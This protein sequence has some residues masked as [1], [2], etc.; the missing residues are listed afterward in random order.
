MN[1]PLLWIA[2]PASVSVILF[3]LRRRER[4]V[5]IIGMAIAL[6]L[7][8]IAWFVPIGEIVDIGPLAVKL[9]DSY[10][11]LGRRFVLDASKATIL[12]LLYTGVAFWFGG[13]IVART[14]NL[15]VPGGLMIVSL[16]V[17]ALAVEPFLY[18]ALLI[19][20]AV[21]VSIPLLVTPGNKV[22]RGVLRYLTFQTLG[23]P[24]IL[25]T[26]WMLAGVE[27]SPGD[28]VLVLHASVL[29]GFG[30]A[31]LLAI[32][33]FHTWIP[34]V[35]EE[36]HPYV[37]AYIFYIFP[38]VIMLF[39]LGFL[40]RYVWLRTSPDLYSILRFAGTIMVVAGGL[41]AAFESNLSRI[42]GFAVMIGIGFSLLA[43]SVS[44]GNDGGGPMLALFLA[45]LLPFGIGLGVWALALT[46]LAG[47]NNGDFPSSEL[48]SFQNVQGLARYLPIA[49]SS[50]V[51]ANFSLAGF[52]LLA[53]FPPRLAL[54]A[55]LTQQYPL[56]SMAALLGSTGLLIAGLRT[57]AIL[58]RGSRE[59][60]WHM[61]ESWGYKILLVLGVFILLLGGILPQFFFIPYARLAEIFLHLGNN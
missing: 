31:F 51:L 21:L 30:F 22:G 26:G 37:A 58:V 35:A 5:V 34:M 18:A 10:T 11:L 19:E 15:F 47:A 49:A 14:N 52:P 2:I 45:L 28:S 38:L 6:L 57:L 36:S 4:I 16:L 33:P 60:E 40:D 23:T 17:A 27:S 32:F 24:F 55:N 12:V 20:M 39:G 7:A 59:G 53:G 42:M 56:T 50:L 61:D 1:A 29:M 44:A 41:W 25:F 54:W 43:L 9:T 46:A 3:F 48:F 13:S 8:M